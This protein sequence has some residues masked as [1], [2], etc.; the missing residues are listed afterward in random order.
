MN[1]KFYKQNT[2]TKVTSEPTVHNLLMRVKGIW[3]LFKFAWNAI[4]P[5][6]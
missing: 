4:V 3:K 1:I 6:F 5:L 2:I